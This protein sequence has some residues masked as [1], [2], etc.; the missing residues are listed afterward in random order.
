MVFKKESSIQLRTVGDLKNY[1]AQLNESP[2]QLS[3]RIPISNMTFRRLLKQDDS[4]ELP[5]KYQRLLET[6]S[7]GHN[8]VDYAQAHTLSDPKSFDSIVEQLA[9]DGEKVEKPEEVE[10]QYKEKVKKFKLDVRFKQALRTLYDEAFSPKSTATMGMA[11]GAILYFLN[12]ADLIPDLI[13]GFGFIDDFSI[14]TL[15]IEAIRRLRS[16]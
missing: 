13:P 6:D 15:M 11:L 12:P 9:T 7:T 1:L 5:E 4:K 3:K 14:A 8:A 2:E 16:A 10:R